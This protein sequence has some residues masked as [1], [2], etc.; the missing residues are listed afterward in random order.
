MIPKISSKNRDEHKPANKKYVKI[1]G[2]KK[3][4]KLSMGALVGLTVAV[5]ASALYQKRQD[6]KI[7]QLLTLAKQHFRFD[8]ILV[9]WLMTVPN[10]PSHP[11]IHA[12]GFV[13]ADGTVVTFD[14]DA[15]SLKIVE[16]FDKVEKAGE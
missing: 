1:K 5:G 2:M 12:G 9:S 10:L 4:L 16:T 7:S 14:V 11:Q 13:R 8:D 3:I 6:Q 15:V